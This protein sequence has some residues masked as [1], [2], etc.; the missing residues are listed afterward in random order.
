M[1]FHASGVSP[2]VNTSWRIRDN[3]VTLRINQEAKHTAIF[4]LLF[5]LFK[6][7]SQMKISRS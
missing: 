4:F 5:S 3:D 2:S 7:P 6:K 1:D